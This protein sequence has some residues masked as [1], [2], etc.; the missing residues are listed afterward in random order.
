MNTST[1]PE[2]LCYC[3]ACA[4]GS[5][6]PQATQHPDD[7]AIHCTRDLGQHVMQQ[8]EGEHNPALVAKKEQ[9][10]IKYLQLCLLGPE[11]WSLWLLQCS[12]PPRAAA[13]EGSPPCLASFPEA[14]TPPDTKQA[15]VLQRV[16]I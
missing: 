3:W 11:R 8:G 7:V 4:V 10:T 1:L 15:Q 12:V 6:A 5:D 14:L 16:Q 13:S 2:C 9:S